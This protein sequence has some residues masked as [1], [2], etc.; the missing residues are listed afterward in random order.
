MINLTQTFL[1]IGGITLGSIVG[2]KFPD[3]DFHIPLLTHRSIFTHFPISMI[4]VIISQVDL[5]PMAQNWIAG[6]C[7]GSGIHLCFDCFPKK[8]QGGALLHIFGMQIAPIASLLLILLGIYI[9]LEIAIKI[10]D[11]TVEKLIAIL[12]NTLIGLHL[13]QREKILF[14]LA[15]FIL[16][17]CIILL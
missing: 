12:I 13:H 9:N 14:P 15:L 5:D 7:L 11:L 17:N 3:V 10:T 8:W 2:L 6:F 4:L 16:M 1:T